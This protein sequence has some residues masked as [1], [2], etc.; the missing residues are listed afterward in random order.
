MGLQ[1][2]ESFVPISLLP[3]NTSMLTHTKIYRQ[4]KQRLIITISNYQCRVTN[5]VMSSCANTLVEHLQ[6]LG[7]KY[8]ALH[9]LLVGCLP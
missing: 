4:A 2:V 1:S 7:A 8:G 5:L 9:R 3:E 6:G